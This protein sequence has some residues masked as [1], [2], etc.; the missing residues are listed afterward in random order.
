MVW[1]NAV[2]IPGENK[3]AKILPIHLKSTNRYIGEISF[4]FVLLKW[5]G[6][7]I[8]QKFQIWSHQTSRY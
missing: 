8:Y 4:D 1:L 3:F 2:D 5:K 6:R 7:R